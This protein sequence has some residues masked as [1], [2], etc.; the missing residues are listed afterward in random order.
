M[1]VKSRRERERERNDFGQVDYNI[2]YHHH[3]GR[4]S[5]F[6]FCLQ[7]ISLHSQKCV[8]YI[9]F[10]EIT[11][12]SAYW[13]HIHSFIHSFFGNSYVQEVKDSCQIQIL[14]RQ[15]WAM[16][17]F[18]LK[19]KKKQI[20]FIRVWNISV[21]VKRFFFRFFVCYNMD[22]HYGILMF[23]FDSIWDLNHHS[24]SHCVW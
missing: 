11:F 22:S 10:C 5:I 12:I 24:I 18:L 19:K 20:Q 14:Q 4:E 3:R 6:L 15:Q 23:S 16:D 21:S 17:F 13:I 8:E 7:W 9:I 1:F 2:P